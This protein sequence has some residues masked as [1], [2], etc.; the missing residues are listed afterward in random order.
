[1]KSSHRTTRR[2]LATTAALAL[3]LAT[4]LPTL[5][6]AE[7]DAAG[8]AYEAYLARE[9]QSQAQVQERADT[10]RA[11]TGDR[12]LAGPDWRAAPESGVG[13]WRFMFRVSK[14]GEQHVRG[15]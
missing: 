13:T 2:P 3:A 7:G 10:T 8:H 5:A 12:Q 9:A 11:G 4:A 1:M 15:R 14:E 6:Q